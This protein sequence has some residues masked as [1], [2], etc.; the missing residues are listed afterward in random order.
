MRMKCQCTMIGA[1]LELA[2]RGFIFTYQNNGGYTIM[3]LWDGYM[4]WGMSILVF[5]RVGSSGQVNFCMAVIL[6]AFIAPLTSPSRPKSVWPLS[7]LCAI[8]VLILVLFSFL[9]S[10]AFLCF[11]MQ[12]YYLAALLPT[13]LKV[14]HHREIVPYFTT[15]V[16]LLII[17]VVVDACL[18][19]SHGSRWVPISSP[20]IYL[21][22]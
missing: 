2:N 7:S 6:G 16:V 3:S 12:S 20:S 5:G 9:T 8:I 14:L 10:P 21:G 11:L 22:S 13:I 19:G 1:S 18:F 17:I 15:A 4:G